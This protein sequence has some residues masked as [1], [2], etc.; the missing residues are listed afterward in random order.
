MIN[1]YYRNQV[2]F[3]TAAHHLIHLIQLTPP[4]S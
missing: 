3:C 4:P 1:S 2:Y